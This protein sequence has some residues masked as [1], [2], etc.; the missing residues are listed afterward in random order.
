MTILNQLPV[1]SMLG[2]PFTDYLN[3]TVPFDIGAEVSDKLLPVIESIGPM[4]EVDHGV[5]RLFDERLKPTGAVFKF[6]KRGKVHVISA[7]GMALAALRSTGNYSNYLRELSLFPHRVSMLHATQDYFVLDP[8]AVILSVKDAAFSEQLFLTRKVLKKAH[9]NALLSPGITG[10]ETGTVYLGNRANADVWAKVYDKQH[11]R[12]QRAGIDPGPIVRVEIAVQSDVGATL[13]DAF[14]PHDLYFHFASKSL[15]EAPQGFQGWVPSGEGFVL[16]ESRE[17]LP[18]DR[19]DRLLD[20]SLDLTRLID[21]A[22]AAYG[23]KSGVVLSR[24]LRKKCDS[25][26][27]ALQAGLV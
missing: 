27:L 15:V 7:S 11:E 25:A 2:V 18:L 23:A 4:S 19:L 16:G 24:L 9:V 26:L 5:Y 10:T 20:F 12:L 22:V 17:I 14:D 21:I 3:V 13:R 6:K 8:S 1:V